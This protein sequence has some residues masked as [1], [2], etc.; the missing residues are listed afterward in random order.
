VSKRAN[1]RAR[2]F[3]EE[4]V[5]EGRSFRVSCWVCKTSAEYMYVVRWS[6]G[7][8][9]CGKCGADLHPPR[10]VARMWELVNLPKPARPKQRRSSSSTRNTS[11]RQSGRRCE[12]GSSGRSG[13]NANAVGGRALCKFITSPMTDWEENAFPIWRSAVLAAIP[14]SMNAGFRRTGTST[15]LRFPLPDRGRL[16][17]IE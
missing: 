1:A 7:E 9:A 4:A 10:K 11:D 5:A 12:A 2:A 14:V 3:F 17:S 8:R 16:Q 15:R 6:R 13:R